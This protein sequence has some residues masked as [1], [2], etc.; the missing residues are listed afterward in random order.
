M[1]S[2]VFLFNFTRMRKVEVAMFSVQDPTTSVPDTHAVPQKKKRGPKQGQ[3]S[4]KVVKRRKKALTDK[5]SDPV[6]NRKSKTVSSTDDITEPVSVP[7]WLR[8]KPALLFICS[9]QGH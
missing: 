8:L 7:G 1:K 6:K 3:P 2:S 4:T 9:Y 5:S